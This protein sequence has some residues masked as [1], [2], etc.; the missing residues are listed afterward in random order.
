[1]KV[2]VTDTIQLQRVLPRSWANVSVLVVGSIPTG[3][4][5][6][7]N[8]PWHGLIYQHVNLVLQ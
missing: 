2:K 8:Y 7:Q 6:V 1:M 3:I 4:F 5:F